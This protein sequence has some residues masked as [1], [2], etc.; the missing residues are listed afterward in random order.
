VIV[1]VGGNA[2]W[3]KLSIACLSTHTVSLGLR[4]VRSAQ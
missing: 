4:H 1:C 3:L 2:I